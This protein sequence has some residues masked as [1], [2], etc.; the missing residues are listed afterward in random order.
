MIGV[1]M[2]LLGLGFYIYFLAIIG[3]VLI[4]SAVINYPFFYWSIN[5]KDVEIIRELDKTKSFVDDYVMVKITVR[6][7]G[8]KSIDYL[9]IEDQIQDP[10]AFTVVLGDN[11]ISTRLDA[12]S[13]MK[14]SYVLYLRLRGEFK[15]G[16]TKIRIK[17]KLGYLIEQQEV[18]TFTSL[19]VYP[20]YDDVR[21]ME[22]FATRR[23]QGLIFGAH[24]T[25]QKGL[26]TE[27]FGIREYVVGDEFR[28]IDWK[29]TARTGN[30][31]I[32]EFETE[33]NIRVMILLDASKTMSTGSIYNN[34]LEYS[35][36]AAL[37]LSK[38]ALERHDQVGLVVYADKVKFF[39]E[40]RGGPNQFWRILEVLS[41][42]KAEGPKK[43]YN[44][45]DFS[46]RRI[47]KD[48]FIFVLS[49]MEDLSRYFISA[50]MLLKSYKHEVIVISPFG[51]WFEVSALADMSVTDRALLEAI[52]EE[53][54]EKRIRMQEKIKRLETNILNVSPQDFFPLIITEY[55][56][57]KKKGGSGI[58]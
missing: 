49:D 46:V 21:R 30:P 54:W 8:N 55:L 47:K 45:A 26:G 34:K 20:T 12:K 31:M 11:K 29:A 7:N 51:P 19:L 33:K 36:R 6:N 43:L 22:A 18:K 24:R 50:I 57:C 10:L 13:E 25:K 16:P 9:E 38:L 1:L 35:I 41:R 48:T 37:L 56:N 58:V 44:A 28:R 14:F 4:F 23:R 32:R 5:L 39:I 52:S 3:A 17:D 42:I 15:I 40:P 2:L 27:F 53:A